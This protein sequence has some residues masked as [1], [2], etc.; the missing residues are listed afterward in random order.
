ML[1]AAAL[2]QLRRCFGKLPSVSL[3]TGGGRA[4]QIAQTDI[5]VY[6]KTPQPKYAWS[7]MHHY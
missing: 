2:D 4:D 3:L 1:I 5:L 6:D 7:L